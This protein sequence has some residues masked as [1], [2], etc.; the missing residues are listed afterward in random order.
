[1]SSKPP[2]PFKKKEDLIKKPQDPKPAK[3]EFGN[4]VNAESIAFY[5]RYA[6]VAFTIL[7]SCFVLFITYGTPEAQTK[8][9]YYYLFLCTFPILI[10]MY[11]VSPL[12]TEKM[13]K[14]TMFLYGGTTIVVLIALYYF[15][16]LTNPT[17][18]SLISTFSSGFI[19]LGFFVGLAI[20]YRVLMRYINMTRGWFGFLLQLLFYIP[21]LIIEFVQGFM[22]ELKVAPNIVFVLVVVE[23]LI[24]LGYLYLPKLLIY[25]RKDS[26]HQLIDSPVFLNKPHVVA[27]NED[28]LLD[29]TKKDMPE[30]TDDVIRANYSIA[31]WVFINEQS[32]NDGNKKNVLS[33]SPPGSYIGKPTV[34]YQGG[35]LYFTLTD[36][37]ALTSPTVLPIPNQKWN[38]VVITYDNQKADVYLNGVLKHSDTFSYDTQPMYS[39]VDV[40]QVGQTEGAYGAIRSLVYYKTPIHLAEVANT[41]NISK[42]TT[43]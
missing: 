16:Q 6:I 14:L 4:F 28:F 21:C 5:K 2:I 36:S 3:F 22:D 7:F 37:Y 12:Y 1:M 42:Y 27:K 38:Y 26:V 35:N 13:T 29:K 32:I 41:Y 33:Y 40:I 39:P 11:L 31:F 43:I 18:V 9:F 23:I 34:K 20:L 17:S 8:H 15:Y 24:V 25:F 30:K 19:F 10:A